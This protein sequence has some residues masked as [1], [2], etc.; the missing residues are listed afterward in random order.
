VPELPEV[1][2]LRRGLERESKGRGI[3]SVVVA[4]PE[5]LRGQSE[6]EF[7]FRTVEKRIMSVERRG[8][9]LLMPLAAD[10]SDSSLSITTICL[11][12]KMR[13]SVRLERS[14]SI[15]EKYLCAE[16]VL[17]SG[18][19]LR[20][21]DVWAWG[22]VRA[23]TNSELGMVSG[24]AKMAEEPLEEGWG[25]ERLAQ[26]IGR[27]STAIKSVLLDQKT[28]AG[29]GNIYADEALFRAR[30]APERPAS[31]LSARELNCLAGAIRSVLMEAVASGGSQGDY[32]DL[33]G[34]PGRYV[35]EV[36]DREGKP[37]PGCAE[38]LHKVRLGG[39]GTTY[40]PTCQN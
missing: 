6:A 39:R 20:F 13:G 16:L 22:E 18:Q 28:V 17:D 31:A 1:E 25:A 26:R 9:Y 24:L 5:V 33:Y 8:K 37:C 12:L 2:T 36:Y 3:V 34:D 30:I 4:R 19:S 40:C 10:G 7:R 11:H 15:A 23:L 21:Y 29:V 35:P 32:V 27:R 14:G 38:P